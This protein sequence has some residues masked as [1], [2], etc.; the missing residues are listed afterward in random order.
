MTEKPPLNEESA[1][2]L[3][4]ELK[5]A[6]SRIMSAAKWVSDERGTTMRV[7]AETVVDVAYDIQSAYFAERPQT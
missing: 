4:A 6:A 5:T 1:Y 3:I 7:A 2:V